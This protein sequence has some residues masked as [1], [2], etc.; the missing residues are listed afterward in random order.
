MGFYWDRPGVVLV[1]KEHHT[2]IAN[3]LMIMRKSFR[4]KILFALVGAT[5]FALAIAVIVTANTRLSA[6]F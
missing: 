4:L 3:R 6:L 5:W 1:G 2:A